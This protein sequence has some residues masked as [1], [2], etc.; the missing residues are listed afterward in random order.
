MRNLQFEFGPLL[1]SDFAKSHLFKKGFVSE[2]FGGGKTEHYKKLFWRF[3]YRPLEIV[4]KCGWPVEKIK[5]RL[6]TNVIR[7]I[8]HGRN[9][10]YRNF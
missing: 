1:F 3:Y 5:G 10:Q 4:G 7:L 6:V 2:T 9:I 8:I